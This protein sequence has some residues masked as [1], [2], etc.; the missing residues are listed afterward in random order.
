MSKFVSLH[1]YTHFSILN[2]LLSPKDLL[3][4]AKELGQNAIA[5]TDRGT[6]AG[7][8]D[9]LK[10]SKETG[11][12]LIT[13]CEFY[14]TDDLSN[15][16]EKPRLIVLI[17]KNYNGYSNLLKLNSAGFDN[18]YIFAKK[19]FPAIDW[20]LLEKYSK[21]IICLTGCG[22]GITGQLINSKKFDDAE[23]AM[24]RLK[25]IFEDNLAVEVQTN[26][27]N[28][29]PTYYTAGVNQIFTN[30]HSIR[31]ADKLGIKIVPTCNTLYSKKEDAE[32]H[33]ALLAIG[34]MQPIY[35]NARV[36]YNV[37]DFYLRSEEEVVKFFSRNYSEEF[38][39]K[40]CENSLYF[41]DQCEGSQWIDL[42]YS[43]KGKELP[44]FPVEDESDYDDYKKWLSTR[45]EDIKKLDQDKSYL[46]YRCEKAFRAKVPAGKEKE[47]V[48][49]LE[50]ELDVLYYCGVSS[51]MLI[52]ADYVKWA[53]E[54]DVSDSPGRG[55][56][57]GETKVLTTNGFKRL[58]EI[59][60]NDSVFSHTG[61][62]RKILNTFKFDVSKEKLFKIKTESS[63]DDIILTKDHKLFASKHKITD[64]YI[65]RMNKGQT[66]CR[67][68]CELDG[69]SW[70]KAEDLVV[71][72]KIYTTFPNRIIQNHILYKDFEVRRSSLGNSKLDKKEIIKFDD[73]FIY[74]LG[75][76]TG[77]G[78]YRYNTNERIYNI[79]FAF[80]SN[81]I[82]GIQRC[83]NYWEKYGFNINPIKHKTK[84]LIQ[85]HIYNKDL[86]EKIKDLFP[87]Y[88]STSGSKHFPVC[89]RSFNDNGLKSLFKGLLDSDGSIKELDRGRIS[90]RYSID[91]ISYRL[92]N[93]AK[94]L[95]LYLKVKSSI[96]RRA[97]FMRGEYLCKES[98]K[99]RFR[100]A[101]FDNNNGHGYFSKILKIEEVED[102]FVYDITVDQDHSYLTSNYIVHN[103]VAGSLIAY[104]LDIHKAD[105][106][107]YGLVFERFHNKLKP[108]Y[109][110]I[111]CDFSKEKR[112]LVIEYIIKKYG[113]DRFA[114]IS[115]YIFITP[116][117]YVKDVSRSFE[118]GGGR[119]EAVKVGESIAE[120]IP[121]LVDGKEVRT[122]NDIMEKS[123][124]F[125]EWTK[126]YP[127]LDKCSK[128]CGK[129]RALG[130]HAAGAIIS[131][132]PVIDIVPTRIDKDGI[133]S[134]QFDK[135]RVEEVGLVKM[136]ILGIETLDIIENTNKLIKSSN[137][138][139]PEIDY[140]GYDE[141][142]YKLISSGDTFGVFQ[143]GT[144]AGTI[145][146]CKKI[147]PK[148]MEDLATITTLARPAS[149]GIREDYVKAREGKIKHK[150]LHPSLANALGPTFGF[151][152]Y[153]ESLLI[154]AKD[155]A[156][157]D[158]AEADK[159]RKLTKEKGK[160]PAKAEKW[161]IEFIEGAVKNKIKEKDAA[162]IWQEIII[163]Y[164]LYSFN[165]SHAVLYS[166]L[167][168]H[169]AYLKAHFPVEFLLANLI[170]ETRS[171]APA[172]EENIEKIKQE[173]RAIG[174]QILPPDINKSKLT[175]FI[176]DN[177]L[178]TGLDALKFV[179][180]EAIEDMLNKRPFKDFNDFIMRTD[181]GKVRSNTIKALVASGCLD[182]FNIPRK[183]M[184]LYCEDYKK[185]AQ[186][187]LKKHDPEKEHFEYPWPEEKEWS[188]PELYALE[189]EYIGEAF[190]CGKRDAYG[191]F[192][193]IPST[194]VKDVINM[195]NKD[196]IQSMRVE[197]KSIFEL[198]VK[199]QT[200]KMLGE[201]MLKATVEDANGDQITLTIFPKNWKETKARIRDLY[202]NKYK[203]EP[204]VAINF[205]GSVNEYNDS[206][207][208]VLNKLFDFAP[209]PKSPKD[210]IAKKTSIKSIKTEEK[211]TNNSDNIDEFISDIEDELFDEGS[212]D[213]NSFDI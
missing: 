21:D 49:R 172:A 55:C 190:I 17:A 165:K 160:N 75:R 44:V 145:D 64:K 119:A 177:K 198:K 179:G 28:R 50:E 109:S 108:S 37:S 207:G 164:S 193:K 1:N 12:K 34:Q 159:L 180:D 206:I 115:N 47:Y 2:S 126:K 101:E 90:N 94:E 195:T 209:A 133:L 205:T 194:Q 39:N 152:L 168:Y 123:P 5:I 154:L 74:W 171:A 63:F 81:D 9:A 117:V 153:D 38:A 170:S 204:G 85:I 203:F 151:P 31:L 26:N 41:A 176:E 86:V 97:P 51:Y 139:V 162:D 199:K 128:I 22:N 186:V 46:R 110:D 43:T 70:I 132:R 124:L 137:K 69:P 120:I 197:V 157:W 68:Y 60:V 100:K 188:L 136:D 67:K 24:S 192:F 103:S 72:D 175:Y 112:H 98:F 84:N 141:K 11:I 163:P 25:N 7:S 201:S 10:V 16:E 71:N 3:N 150:L 202:G 129:P 155:V 36:R 107:K 187:W 99:L 79:G 92:I 87:D 13:G 148:C 127:E 130:I 73:E 76:F 23:A 56:L 19:T 4:K 182:G 135:D 174:V 185:K 104:L 62:E 213:L 82:D 167:T 42:S 191:N 58:D 140:N 122:Y 212:I 118:L 30:L 61:K 158:L 114:Q 131:N 142:A 210:K 57:T 14:F 143:F 178:L 161:R 121:K 116:K 78:W 8:W 211:K 184:F 20:K 173:L 208:V 6:L 96:S 45:R 113:K 189:K 33:D 53:R 106:I 48:A 88:V 156:G 77:D 27:L 29:G 35:S 111:D 89:F 66:A 138:K 105:P 18:R 32:I 102:K 149:K 196:E 166:M 93:E 52:V 59:K 144:S 54:N 147:Q 83:K 181:G 40:I 146:L 65:D 95:L 200:S 91:S 15:K 183:L 80:N 134:T 169:T 125:S